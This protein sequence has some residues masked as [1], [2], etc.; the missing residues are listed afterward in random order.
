MFGYFWVKLRKILTSS[1]RFIISFSIIQFFPFYSSQ[2]SLT[3]CNAVFLL[4]FMLYRFGERRGFWY[5]SFSMNEI[6][7]LF[8]LKIK[9]KS[10]NSRVLRLGN[11]EALKKRILYFSII[12]I[13]KF[14]LILI[15]SSK[16]NSSLQLSIKWIRLV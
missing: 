10:S 3:L 15:L 4:I 6:R 13:E 12:S 7:L 11:K 16:G 1:A 2:S 5:S 8:V 9:V 14:S